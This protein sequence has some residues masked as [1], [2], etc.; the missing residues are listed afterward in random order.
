[1][2]DLLRIRERREAQR[3]E[4]RHRGIVGIEELAEDEDCLRLHRAPDPHGIAVVDDLLELRHRA[5]D[6]HGRG[7]IEHE[8][9]SPLLAVLGHED[10]GAAEVR[11]EQGRRRD[12]EV[13]LE[14]VHPP[15]VATGGYSSLERY[16]TI[17]T[18]SSVSIPSPTI[19]S[20]IGTTR[21][22]CSGV[23]TISITTGR[24]SERRRIRDVWRCESA[25]NPSI[26]RSTVAPASPSWRTRSTIAW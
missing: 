6:L 21:S 10:D 13:S 26:P 2:H 24:S 16:E 7:A 3:P 20:R 12:E 25:P 9:G 18:R 5:G 19:S 14:R 17:C 8:P 23:S 11:V 15:I 4:E 1:R 22:I